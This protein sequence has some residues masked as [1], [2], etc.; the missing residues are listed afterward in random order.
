M[1]AA[2]SVSGILKERHRKSRF[3]FVNALQE[4]AVIITIDKTGIFQSE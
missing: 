3:S 2:N 1:S 4:D